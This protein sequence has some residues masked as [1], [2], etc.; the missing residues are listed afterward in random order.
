MAY[1]S[2]S[3]LK[4]LEPQE[5]EYLSEEQMVSD[6]ELPPSGGAKKMW[7]TIVGLLV[8]ILAIWYV[9]PN[10]TPFK[11]LPALTYPW[12]SNQWQAVFLSNGQVYFG[13]ISRVTWNAVIIKNVYYLQVTNQPLQRTI[14]GQAASGTTNTAQNEAQQ[15]ITLVKLGNEIHGP[16]D[17]I[18][19]NRD[20]VL[21]TEF[22]KGD[23]QV[24]KAIEQYLKELSTKK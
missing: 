23:G 20:Q 8:A 24:V 5:E 15:S 16:T 9:V 13:K 6:Y 22:L 21:F 7:L 1:K 2:T 17:E 10:Y 18:R 3:T 11:S 14:E 19:I 4:K 12:P